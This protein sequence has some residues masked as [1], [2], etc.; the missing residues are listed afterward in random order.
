MTDGTITRA[1]PTSSDAS[2]IGTSATLTQYATE[3]RFQPGSGHP[4]AGPRR[5]RGLWVHWRWATTLAAWPRWRR[6]N[7]GPARASR[8]LRAL[9]WKLSRR[10]MN[11]VSRRGRNRSAGDGRRPS[12]SRQTGPT[13]A[14]REQ[15]H[16]ETGLDAADDRF[17]RAEF[18]KANPDDAAMGK[19]R[20]QD[21]AI[22]AA[23]AQDD[24]AQ[25]I[26]PR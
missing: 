7:S 13:R 23:G 12:S 20:F 1:A 19:P 22:R 6:A 3:G 21:Q 26:L 8:A 14:S 11:S 4:C 10:R 24:H 25:I 9:D 2:E 5:A 18:E 15:R 17:E 16:A